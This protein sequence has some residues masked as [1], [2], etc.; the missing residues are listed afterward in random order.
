MSKEYSG[1]GGIGL[2][3]TKGMRGAAIEAGIFSKN[4]WEECEH[5][6][7]AGIGLKFEDAGNYDESRWYL[8]VEGANLSE[9]NSNAEKFVARLSEIGAY[10]AAD[11]LQVISDYSVF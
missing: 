8:L 7:M 10:V 6:C 9:I 5:S 1:V 2:Q 4:D 11:G 3:F